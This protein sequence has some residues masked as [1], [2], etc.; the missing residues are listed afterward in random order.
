MNNPQMQLEQAIVH[1][2]ADNSITSNIRTDSLEVNQTNIVKVKKELES[3]AVEEK[4]IERI[5]SICEDVKEPHFPLAEVCLGISSLLVGAFFSAIISGVPFV[6][7]WKAIV[8]YIIC[9]VIASGCGVAFG[10]IREKEQVT[11]KSLADHV[12]EYL[13]EIEEYNEGG[14]DDES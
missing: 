5:K 8:F 1:E 14:N 9:P 4:D 11:A 2:G 3:I 7:G 10:F 13:P 6:L 12:L